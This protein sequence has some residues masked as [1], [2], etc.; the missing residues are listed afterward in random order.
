MANRI[1]GNVYIIDS[2]MG[3]ATDLQGVNTASWQQHQMYIA[4][5]ALWCANTTA[6]IELIYKADTTSTAI[7]LGAG[8]SPTPTA[9]GLVEIYLGGVN[10]E[11]LRVKTLTAGTGFIYFK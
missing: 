11:E 9:G 8:N 7:R 10:F 4:S 3:A 5:V 6:E 2:Q 1:V